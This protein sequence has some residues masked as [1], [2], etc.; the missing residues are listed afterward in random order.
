[1]KA[2]PKPAWPIV[3]NLICRYGAAQ[4]RPSL[5]RAA[6]SRLA[7]EPMIPTSVSRVGTGSKGIRPILGQPRRIPAHSGIGERVRERLMQAYKIYPLPMEQLRLPLLDTHYTAPLRR[8]FLA[9]RR[10]AQALTPCIMD[11]TPRFRCTKLMA[12]VA[13]QPR[14]GALED[15][16][17]GGGC[18]ASA[19]SPANQWRQPRLA[20]GVAAVPECRGGRA[21]RR[22]MAP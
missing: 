14:G 18:N 6:D 17:K 12:N 4:K 5:D 19:A 9:A 8:R 7:L 11:R 15:E 3:Y 16:T 13:C 22:W 2:A 21:N 10:A 1:M 20:T